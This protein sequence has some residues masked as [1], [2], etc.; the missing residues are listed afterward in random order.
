M[1]GKFKYDY[2][3]NKEK[4]PE[5]RGIERIKIGIFN[6]IKSFTKKVGKYLFE[7][8]ENSSKNSRNQE[9]QY[10]TYQ[11]TSAIYD[12]PSLAC[13]PNPNYSTPS[14]NN[15]MN[16]SANSN[17]KLSNYNLLGSMQKEEESKSLDNS[18]IND[19]GFIPSKK[20]RSNPVIRIIKYITSVT[21][22]GSEKIHSLAF[23]QTHEGGNT[24]VS[25]VNYKKLAE[26]DEN[27]I[28]P[29][30]IYLSSFDPK[31]R[32][33]MREEYSFDKLY[34]KK[35]DL[36]EFPN[37]KMTM[38]EPKSITHSSKFPLIFRKSFFE[39]PQFFQIQ[40]R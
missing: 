1:Y 13:Y 30:P 24:L 12:S 22:R 37:Y 8:E 19:D 39:F 15:K 29:S 6:Y 3:R 20:K 36:K 25:V 4:S 26:E 18:K 35:S 27:M 31:K 14:G 2:L 32:K 17:I 23:K 38:S 5:R 7:N 34:T 21:S 16:I 11:D 28:R 40:E 10:P 33:R 9:F